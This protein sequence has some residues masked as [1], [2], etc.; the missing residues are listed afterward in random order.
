[1]KSMI[2]IYVETIQK[3]I[4]IKNKEFKQ[5]YKYKNELKKP[6]EKKTT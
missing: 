1:M 2:K 3:N 6:T 5:Y 4:E